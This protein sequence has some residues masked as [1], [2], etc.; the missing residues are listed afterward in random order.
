M[1]RKR[2]ITTTYVFPP[3]PVR[4]FYWCAHYE[5]EEEAGDYGWGPTEE[6][7]IEDF[8]EN[9]AENHDARLDMFERVSK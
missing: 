2:R 3:I 4:A 5:G 9:H 8:L 6:D 7:A 1:I